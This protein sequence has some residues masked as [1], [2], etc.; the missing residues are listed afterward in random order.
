MTRFWQGVNTEEKN[1]N[2]SKIWIQNKAFFQYQFKLCSVVLFF[3]FFLSFVTFFRS[4]RE[5]MTKLHKA[6]NI[7]INDCLY[8][9]TIIDARFWIIFYNYMHILYI[10]MTMMFI[11]TPFKLYNI[12]CFMFFICCMFIR[13][14]LLF[15]SVLIKRI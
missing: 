12:L 5:S 14:S 7:I 4:F 2:N 15:C 1:C 13:L 8:L 3:R 11:T 9:Y 6:W 10:C